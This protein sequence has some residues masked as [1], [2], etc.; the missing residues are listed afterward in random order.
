MGSK[1]EGQMSLFEESEKDFKKSIFDKMAIKKDPPITFRYGLPGEEEAIQKLGN[2]FSKEIGW[3]RLPQITV[4]IERKWCIVAVCEDEIVGFNLLAV[5]KKAR[6]GL[7]S[8][9]I[10]IHPEY[11]RHGIGRKFREYAIELLERKG[12][13]SIIAKCIQC[14]KANYL[15]QS[16]GFKLI[17]MDPGKYKPLNIWCYYN[18]NIPEK[19]HN[20]DLSD[21]FDWELITDPEKYKASL[22]EKPKKGKKNEKHTD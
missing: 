6:T 15:N 20:P 2:N 3:V 7:T 14:S 10:G 17:K 4:F 13:Q 5:V 19:Y 8:N 11:L 12:W 22:P 21:E 9:N 16:M 1:V 18:R